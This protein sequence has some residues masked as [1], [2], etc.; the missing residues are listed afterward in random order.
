MRHLEHRRDVWSSAATYDRFRF[1]RQTPN[2][3]ES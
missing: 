2:E 3:K 1:W